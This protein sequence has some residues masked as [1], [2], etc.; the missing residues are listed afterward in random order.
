VYAWWYGA[1]LLGIYAL[2]GVAAPASVFWAPV[3]A[4]M[5]FL[6]VPPIIARRSRTKAA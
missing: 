5:V 2:D 4:C 1:L 6:V 3:A